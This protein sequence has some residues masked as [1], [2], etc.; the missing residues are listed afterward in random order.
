M[1]IRTD[2]LRKKTRGYTLVE[3]MVA[4]SL[5]MLA[6]AAAAALSMTLVNQEEI[7]ARA[8]RA[9]N[10]HENAV[11]LFHLGIGTNS[12]PTAI[13]NILPGL[14]GMTGFTAVTAATTFAALPTGNDQIDV[15]NL[16]LSFT[17]DVNGT[18]RVNVITA[19]R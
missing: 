8:A 17:S 9:L 15:T 16:T 6:V 18:T 7:N 12:D 4:I 5:L 14:P 11:R 19:V 1:I 10:W 2:R 3:A 13:V